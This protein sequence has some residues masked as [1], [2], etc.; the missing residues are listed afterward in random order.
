MLCPYGN[1]SRALQL[2]SLVP[3]KSALFSMVFPGIDIANPFHLFRQGCHLERVA[4]IQHYGDFVGFA[5]H[6]AHSAAERFRMRTMGQS[7]RMER[8]HAR[9]DVVAREELATMIKN[10]LVVI[11]VV[12][13]KRQ[14][15]CS[16]V[17]F[18]RTRAKSA[19]DETRRREGRM[20]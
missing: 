13:K 4:G 1:R 9:M 20:G 14:L 17:G 7:A 11:V 8:N 15:Q 3:G 18:Q 10:D 16:W 6:T 12:V 5:P 2:M 19:N